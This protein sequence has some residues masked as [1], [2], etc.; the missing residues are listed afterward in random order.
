[1]DCVTLAA[2]LTTAQSQTAQLQAARDASVAIRDGAMNLYTAAATQSIAAQT[3]YDNNL[4][5]INM[6]ESML[7]MMNCPGYGA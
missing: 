3:A 6:L 1:M 7:R 2:Q 5:T 4:N